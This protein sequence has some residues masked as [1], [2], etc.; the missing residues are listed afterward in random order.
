MLAL[1]VI[2]RGSSNFIGFPDICSKAL[3]DA[4]F[5]VMLFLVLHLLG[6]L[7]EIG[8][9]SVYFAASLFY[10]RISRGPKG[11]TPSAFSPSVQILCIRQ[12]KPTTPE[13][14]SQ[15]HRATNRDSQST[16][17]KQ[18]KPPNDAGVAP[19]ANDVANGTEQQT[20]AENTEER[21][22]R[23]AQFRLN[24]IYVWA[25]V[26]GVIGGLCVLGVLVWQNILTRRSAQ[27]AL[28]SARAAI[29]SERAYITI[30]CSAVASGFYHFKA[31]NE[32][33]TPA[34]IT[35]V[36]SGF[37]TPEN[38]VEIPQLIQ[39]GEE[40]FTDP[41]VLAPNSDAEIR[42]WAIGREVKLQEGKLLVYYGR[43][44]YRD[45]LGNTHE[46]RFCLQFDPTLHRL[47]RCGPKGCNLHT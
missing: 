38:E 33:R 40:Q 43:V 9:R 13:R 12:V 27:A 11:F 14:P 29:S 8:S 10:Y 34:E 36:F 46:S 3:L 5:V 20:T 7:L 2:V 22:D 45:I 1:E 35:S 30:G 6:G 26:V 4:G 25:T 28:L 21:S 16:T 41:K 32:G 19:A 18:A 15:D 23:K 39:Y 47:V 37:I 24:R 44:C 17:K 31:T 42:E